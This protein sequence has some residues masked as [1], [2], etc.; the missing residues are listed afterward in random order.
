MSS[1]PLADP[2]AWEEELKAL[3]EELRV[4]TIGCHG[5]Q[6]LEKIDQWEIA[7]RSNPRIGFAVA[8]HA[9]VARDMLMRGVTP[10]KKLVILIHGIRDQGHWMEMVKVRLE[11]DDVVV[12]PIDF[13]F[14]DVVRFMI[15][16]GVKGVID[17]VLAKIRHAKADNG[18]AELIIIAHSFG[19]YVVAKILSHEPDIRCSRAIF[20]GSVIPRAFRFDLVPHCPRIVNECG[21][22]DIW[23][24]I[25]EGFSCRYRYGSAGV[26]GLRVSGIYDR[27][28]DFGHS[29]YLVP[30][31]VESYW[32]PYVD[33]AEIILSPHQDHRR[34]VPQCV[35]LLSYGWRLIL[36]MLALSGLVFG[37][38]CWL[39]GT[40]ST[41]LGGC[42]CGVVIAGTV[43]LL[44][45]LFAGV[46]SYCSPQK[47]EMG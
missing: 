29:D 35:S 15:G 11:S 37:S 40:G 2:N 28:H 9:K 5:A 16:V 47:V 39:Y 3:A 8:E 20:C 25:A 38:G 32:K 13:Q 41:L 42:I 7:H 4:S 18:S 26:W 10:H 19:T 27:F 45:W 33:R 12:Q 44:W 1:G 34:P 46:R 17:R 22:R 6:C 31:F 30:E 23:P 14:F 24:V 36:P 43:A 21:S